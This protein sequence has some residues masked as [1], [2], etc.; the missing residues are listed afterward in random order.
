MDFGVGDRFALRRCSL[1][2]YTVDNPVL[3]DHSPGGWV[4]FALIFKAFGLSAIF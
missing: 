1:L 2:H 4:F 3:Q